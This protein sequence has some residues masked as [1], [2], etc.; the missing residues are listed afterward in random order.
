MEKNK[1]LG[2]A[3]VG[4][5]LSPATLPRALMT[6]NGLDPTCA[7]KKNIYALNAA[8]ETAPEKHGELY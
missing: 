2:F 3:F 5:K 8:V 7:R 1:R 6:L 4:M